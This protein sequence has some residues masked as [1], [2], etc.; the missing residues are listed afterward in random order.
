MDIKDR[1]RRRFRNILCP[2]SFGKM[3]KNNVSWSSLLGH[4]DLLCWIG[5][6]RRM[7]SKNV[8]C[9]MFRK[10]LI[11]TILLIYKEYYL[12]CWSPTFRVGFQIWQLKFI[13]IIL[14]TT[15]TSIIVIY[16]CEKW[17]I[18]VEVGK[19]HAIPDH[20]QSP[21]GQQSISAMKVRD[22]RQI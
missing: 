11:S 6:C 21:R 15:R 19:G 12:V 2:M 3:S 7:W 8:Y 1:Q 13:T 17:G 22:I 18:W 20:E 16:S 14:S 10:I 4:L 9:H 5:I